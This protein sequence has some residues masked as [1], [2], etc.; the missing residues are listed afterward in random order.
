MGNKY[1]KFL[2][3]ILIITILSIIGILGF[4]AFKIFNAEKTIKKGSE[5]VTE[6]DKNTGNYQQDTITGNDGTSKT[7]NNIDSNVIDESQ[8]SLDKLLTEI[9]DDNTLKGDGNTTMYSKP[10]ETYHDGFKVIGTISIPSIKVEYPI[11]S[12]NNS[13]AAKKAIV[14]VY[15][16]KSENAVNKVGN[17]VLWGHNYKDGTFFSNIKKLNNGAKIYIKDTSGNQ[18]TYKVY[19]SYETSDSDMTYATRDTNGG[20]E[21]TLSTCSITSGRRDIVWAKEAVE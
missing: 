20:K 13:E 9:S 7:K 21:I 11:L 19:N 2:T 17:L 3:I 5:T 14:A 4:F 1:G 15:P 6:F 16:S 10:N 8:G 12:E 18:V